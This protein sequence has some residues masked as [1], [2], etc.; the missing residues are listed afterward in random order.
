[1]RVCPRPVARQKPKQLYLQLKALLSSMSSE[2]HNCILNCNNM[3][4][5]YMVIDPIRYQTK[6]IQSIHWEKSAPTTHPQTPHSARRNSSNPPPIA[7][8]INVRRMVAL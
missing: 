4:S 7:L 2:W 1:M 5:Y 8:E 3:D 6:A